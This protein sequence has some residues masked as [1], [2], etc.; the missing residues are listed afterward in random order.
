MALKQVVYVSRRDAEGKA[1]IPNWAIISISDPFHYPASLRGNWHSI[2]RLEFSDIE[3]EQKFASLF[4]AKDANA[5]IDFAVKA[6]AEGCEGV[7]V[8]CKA[9]ISRSAAIAKWIAAEYKIS[10]EYTF[11]GYNQHVFSTLCETAQG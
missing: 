9:G 8:H 2:L 10:S 7:L 6:N 3:R 11:D 1:G 5:I 4:S